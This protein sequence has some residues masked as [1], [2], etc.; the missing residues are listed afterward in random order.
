MLIR[1]TAFCLFFSL[2]LVLPDLLGCVTR[3]IYI[4]ILK[5]VR[6][7][8]SSDNTHSHRFCLSFL[9]RCFRPTLVSSS[10]PW[11]TP[12][13]TGVWLSRLTSPKAHL[14]NRALPHQQPT[15]NKTLQ[16]SWKQQKKKREK[17]KSASQ[18]RPEELCASAGVAWHSKRGCLSGRSYE[19]MSGFSAKL[20]N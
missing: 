6:F 9:S 8:F 5:K 20:Q 16:D 2:S 1:T 3:N 7:L 19:V 14:H 4:Y 15:L 17:E 12:T 11:P 10:P 13:Y 18:G